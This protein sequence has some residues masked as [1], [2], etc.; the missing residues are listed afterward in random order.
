MKKSGDR[1]L[2]AKAVDA[3]G[4]LAEGSS[5]DRRPEPLSSVCQIRLIFNLRHYRERRQ[6]AGAI[7]CAEEVTKGRLA[8]S[9]AV[10]VA[11]VAR[12]CAIAPGGERGRQCCPGCLPMLW[13]DQWCALGLQAPIQLQ[14]EPS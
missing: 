12:L 9:Q 14:V 10:E 6:L 8:F 13:S 4:S 5:H 3:A 7:V 11:H 1:R 2:I